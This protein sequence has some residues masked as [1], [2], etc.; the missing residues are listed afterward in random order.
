M[1]NEKLNQRNHVSRTCLVFTTL[2]C[3]NF[4]TQGNQG[5][6]VLRQRCA[7]SRYFWVLPSEGQVRFSYVGQT[8]KQYKRMVKVRT[9][10]NCI[11]VQHA[12]PSFLHND[13]YIILTGY[14]HEKSGDTRRT[15]D[16]LQNNTKLPQI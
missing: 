9:I 5:S 16:G 13:L 14:Q 12:Q 15:G 10:H 11:H 3:G 4:T 6:S 1:T 8:C 7:F 2:T